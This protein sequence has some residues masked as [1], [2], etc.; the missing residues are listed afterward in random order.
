MGPES[1]GSTIRPMRHIRVT[2]PAAEVDLASGL[3]WLSGAEGIE[4]QPVDDDGAAEGGVDLIVAT[5]QPRSLLDGLAGRWPTAE[6]QRDPDEWTE[7]WKPFAVPVD[8]GRLVVAPPW[9]EVGDGDRLVVR[10]DPGRAWGHGAHPTTRLVLEA[11]VRRPPVALRVLDL[12]CGSGVLAVAALVLGADSVHAVDVDPAALDATR[13]N[14]ELNGVAD[15]LVCVRADADEAWAWPG[16][17]DPGLV[18][19]NI[20]APVLEAHAAELAALPVHGRLV[21]SGMLDERAPS[22]EAA[23]LDAARAAGRTVELQGRSSLDGWTALDL[24]VSPHE[25]RSVA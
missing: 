8:L 25:P 13:S 3:A 11:L 18:L 24:R 14:A 19:A 16:S 10:I 22:I 17:G 12:G 9:V 6:E 5:R 1:A 7:S 4:E 15:R 21:L 2:V 20:D 23:V